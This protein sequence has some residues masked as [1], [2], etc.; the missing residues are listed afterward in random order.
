MNGFCCAIGPDVSI[1]EKEKFAKSIN[2]EGNMNSESSFEQNYCYSTSFLA[3]SPLK[4]ERVYQ[5]DSMTFLFAGDLI[6]HTHIP[7]TQIVSNFEKSNYQWFS[8]LEGHFAIAIINK[9]TDEVSLISDR[10]SQLSLNYGYVD[11]TFIF[12]TNIA[13]FSTLPIVPKFNEEWLYEYVFFN[14]PIHTTTFFHGVKR[15]SFASVLTVDIASQKISKINYTNNFKPAKKLL[16]GEKAYQEGLKQF[17]NQIPKYFDQTNSNYIAF[18]G[19]FDS[20]TILSLA[21]EKTPLTSYTYGIEGSSDLKVTERLA[22]RLKIKNKKVFFGEELEKEMPK[23]IYDAVRLSGGMGTVLRST[24]PY[25]YKSLYDETDEKDTGVIISGIGGDFFR[26][27]DLSPFATTSSSIMSYGI[28]QYYH[29]GIMTPQKDKLPLVFKKDYSLFENHIEKTLEKI[30][31]LYGEHNDPAA[32]M[33]YDVYE[34][35]PKY[36]GG[37]MA[38]ANNY[39]TFRAPYLNKNLLNFGFN[40]KISNLGLSPYKGEKKYLDYKRYVFQSKVMSSVKKIR[41]TYIRGLPIFMFAMNNFKLFKITRFF[42]RGIAY[43]KGYKVGTARLENWDHWFKNV[44]NKEFDNILDHKCLLS[45]YIEMSS[46]EKI[47]KSNDLLLIN[48]LVTT[49]I[50]LNLIKNKWNIKD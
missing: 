5:N 4:G 18:T 29:K 14:F 11:K 9:K 7:W 2:L 30:K 12:S 50:L 20:R 32:Y 23:L 13:T 39:F 37:E 28:C 21:P 6:D 1:I 46:I 35:S 45:E 40:S 22:K 41:R 15:L 49:E 33:L 17:K 26:G 24:L 31:S 34:V 10:R 16:N 19:G 47:K 42:V 8:E 3:S 44:L 43:L 25:V 48:Q 27:D 38:I 36:F